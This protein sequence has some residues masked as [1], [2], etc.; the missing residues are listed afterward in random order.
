MCSSVLTYRKCTNRGM[1]YFEWEVG[2]EFF[3]FGCLVLQDNQS[4][5]VHLIHFPL[6]LSLSLSFLFVLLFVWHC[7]VIRLI[8]Q[9]RSIDMSMNLSAMHTHSVLVQC[10][11]FD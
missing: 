10:S 6:S 9:L 2:E 1:K 7:R 3:V 11:G 8:F 5:S 4:L